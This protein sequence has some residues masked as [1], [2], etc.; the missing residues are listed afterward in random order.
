MS[1][2]LLDDDDDDNTEEDTIKRNGLLICALGF[3]CIVVVVLGAGFIALAFGGET[4]A[5]KS[6][7]LVLDAPAFAILGGTVSGDGGVASTCTGTLMAIGSPTTNF[8]SG[9]VLVY[10]TNA[11]TTGSSYAHN[12]TLSSPNALAGG[13]FGTAV[14][15]TCNGS[16]LVIGE[17]LLSRVHIF[18]RTKGTPLLNGGESP[19]TQ[20]ELLQSLADGNA[21][22]DLFG[23]SVD[24]ACNGS[25]VVVGAPF[26]NGGDGQVSVYVRNETTRQY[27]RTLV[28]NGTEVGGR[29]GSALG[30][31]CDTSRLVVGAPQSESVVFFSVTNAG[32]TAALLSARNGSDVGA[33]TGSLF[34]A[35]LS[36]ARPGGTTVAVGA[37]ND[38]GARG[39]VQGGAVYLLEDTDDNGTYNVTQ[40]QTLRGT[41]ANDRFGRSVS[42]S[43]DGA[44]RL[45]VGYAGSLLLFRAGSSRTA[46]YGGEPMTTDA[47]AY[48]TERALL[49]GEVAY[50]RNG[51]VVL[52]ANVGNSSDPPYRTGAVGCVQPTSTTCSCA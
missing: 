9:V 23:G 44:A 42:L 22:V 17:A 49:V 16:T 11:T 40:P 47:F 2:S 20:Y 13:L 28:L 15:I 37:P 19:D 10:D 5:K 30:L 38:V 52:V 46:V 27:A 25:I 14:A 7:N 41:S 26:A 36:V 35:S 8:S 45:A 21:G 50:A 1:T 32:N 39:V 3:C 51:N 43:N 4:C 12:Q 31:S 48:A 33:A 18:V 34:G 6:A 29:F 24:V